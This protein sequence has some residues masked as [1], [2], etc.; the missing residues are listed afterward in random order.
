MD[1]VPLAAPDLEREG[2][3]PHDK[4]GGTK[5]AAAHPRGLHSWCGDAATEQGD[6]SPPAPS[7]VFVVRWR[8]PVRGGRRRTRNGRAAL[9][10][11]SPQGLAVDA[12]VDIEGVVEAFGRRTLP[13]L[14]V[15][16]GSLEVKVAVVGSWT[17]PT[18]HRQPTSL[19]HTVHTVWDIPLCYAR[20]WPRGLDHNCREPLVLPH[21]I[22]P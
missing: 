8:L 16:Q 19:T 10:A 7:V 2:S 5:L 1:S 14:P 18:Q 13:I 21:L 4:P 9:H 20:Q 6:A 3:I 15:I 11:S 22:D 12:V 17:A